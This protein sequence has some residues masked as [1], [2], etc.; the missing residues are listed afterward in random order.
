MYDRC[1]EFS[2]LDIHFSNLQVKTGSFFFSGLKVSVNASVFVCVKETSGEKTNNGIHYRLQLLYSNGEHTDTCARTSLSTLS[3]ATSAW[4]LISSSKFSL[5][6]KNKNKTLNKKNESCLQ[7]SEMKCCNG[8][9]RL[10]EFMWRKLQCGD[11]WL[12]NLTDFY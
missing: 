1:E 12:C 2:K 4:F 6:N 8:P 9:S 5:K 11:S 10:P 7:S 3:F